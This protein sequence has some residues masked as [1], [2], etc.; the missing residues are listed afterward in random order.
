MISL[1]GN[2]DSASR[3]PASFNAGAYFVDPGPGVAAL[4]S[5]TARERS[6]VERS[7][8]SAVSANSTSEMRSAGVA[9][10]IAAAAARWARVHESP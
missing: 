2:N 1:R 7:A 3:L 5:A 10:S 4:I 6:G 8:T 9:L